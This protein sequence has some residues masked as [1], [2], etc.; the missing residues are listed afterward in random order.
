MKYSILFTLS[1]LLLFSQNTFS[2]TQKT[3]ELQDLKSEQLAPPTSILKDIRSIPSAPKTILENPLKNFKTTNVFPERTDNQR[4]IKIK[5][6]ESTGLPVWIYGKLANAPQQRN[7]SIESRTIN[8]LDAIKEPLQIEN[9]AEEFFIQKIN[10]DKL[11]HQH[12]RM[13]Q[14]F[15]GVKIYNSEIIAH[16][17]D[18]DI[19]LVNGR[20][21]PTPQ[22]EN[23]TPTIDLQNA[24][25]VARNDVGTFKTLSFEEKKYV[26]GEQFES[27]LVIFF[28]E[29]STTNPRLAYHL[30][31]IPNMIE[32]W[33]YLI[34]AENG[35]ILNKYSSICKFH[36]H[37]ENHAT[38]KTEISK[39]TLE[40]NEN[41]EE[42]VNG[43]F[44]A[45]E[46]DLLGITRTINTCLLYTSPSPRDRG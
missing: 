16:A 19:Y 26:A 35:N 38:H 7:T 10:T 43:P 22:L 21:Y 15:Q 4:F 11:G 28:P 12:I 33:E 2:Q 5:K 8:Y 13:Q 18:N 20:H 6:D 42:I 17:K 14:Q 23:I 1:F 36:A 29:K 44:T 9:P 3:K 40:R 34:D 39:S 46:T 30:T 31:V 45:N 37:L 32:R 24:K 27:E 25:Q 41:A